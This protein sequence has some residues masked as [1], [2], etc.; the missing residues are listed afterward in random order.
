MWVIVAINYLSLGDSSTELGAIIPN[1][2]N[3][4]PFLLSKPKVVKY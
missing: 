4:K 3:G 2:L 1:P